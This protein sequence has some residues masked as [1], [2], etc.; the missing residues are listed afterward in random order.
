[1]FAFIWCIFI[2]AAINVRRRTN[3]AFEFFSEALPGRLATALCQQLACIW[4]H[5]TCKRHRFYFHFYSLQ[6]LAKVF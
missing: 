2:G 5:F 6:N 4:N 3:F 1:V